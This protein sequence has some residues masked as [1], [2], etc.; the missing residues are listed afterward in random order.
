[1]FA[2]IL[3]G[4]GLA[5]LTIIFA[6]IDGN[7]DVT[8]ANTATGGNGDDLLVG[9]NGIVMLL[10]S[11]AGEDEL[12]AAGLVVETPLNTVLQSDAERS[13]IGL[14]FSKDAEAHELYPGVDV[15]RFLIGGNQSALRYPDVDHK[16]TGE[17]IT[18][19]VPAVITDFE[20]GQD[21]LIY[22]H[23]G[24]APNINVDEDLNGNAVLVVDGS[25]AVTFRDLAAA[26]LSESDLILQQWCA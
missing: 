8:D 21:V 22:H 19:D 13:D 25:I 4:L 26:Y 7:D 5:V 3:I 14:E 2:L 1:M 6:T 9:T 17:W 23:D 11:G 12:T 20:P 24:P 16:D 18:P 10:S 15:D